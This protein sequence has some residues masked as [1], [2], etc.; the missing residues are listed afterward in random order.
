LARRSRDDIATEKS[1]SNDSTLRIGDVARLIGVSPSTIRSWEREGLVNPS[2]PGGSHRRYTLAE[3]DR[4]RAAQSLLARGYGH[5]VL[6]A[7]EHGNDVPEQVLA[8]ARLRPARRKR[9]M[10]LRGL[11][12]AAGVSPSYLSLVERGLAQPS[13]SVLRRVASAYGGTVVEFFGPTDSGGSPQNLV[14]AADRRK[15]RGFDRVMMEQIVAFPNA[16]LQVEI[17]TVAPGGGS[18]GN[19]SHDGE[20]VLFILEGHLEVFL[21]EAEHYELGAGDSLYFLS[22][23]PHRWLNSGQV[24][25]RIFWVN[26]P[27]TF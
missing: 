10:S 24:P 1:T 15:L 22:S 2:R 3:V 9:G 17:F 4:L 18:G 16:I 7:I 5:S 25:T 12:A 26:T 20:E 6:R 14:R 11:A 8:G 21:D 27:P 19:Y 13:V 23:Q